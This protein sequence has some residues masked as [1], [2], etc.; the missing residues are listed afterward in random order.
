MAS[1]SAFAWARYGFG[2]A[3]FGGQPPDTPYV[4]DAPHDLT[5]VVERLAAIFSG[6]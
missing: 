6:A 4:L 1:G 5:P 3:R 2:A